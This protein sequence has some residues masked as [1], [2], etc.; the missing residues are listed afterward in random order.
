MPGFV[1]DW[2][3]LICFLSVA[4]SQ[5]FPGATKA[6]RLPIRRHPL[7]GKDTMQ[8]VADDGSPLNDDDMCLQ[9]QHA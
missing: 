8:S 3:C 4:S 9:L 2:D 7:V 1:A 6:Q 5:M